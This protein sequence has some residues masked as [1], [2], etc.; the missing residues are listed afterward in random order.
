LNND[1]GSLAILCATQSGGVNVM[2]EFLRLNGADNENNSF[3]PFDLN[4]NALKTSTGDLAIDTTASTG[5][6]NL[7]LTAKPNGNIALS[8]T[9]AGG[10][11]V[12]SA[13]TANGN[14]NLTTTGLGDIVIFSEDTS[15]ITGK[16]GLTLQTVVAGSNLALTSAGS[17]NA[18]STG[19][20]IALSAATSTGAGIITLAPKNA[21]YVNIPSQSD[22]TNDYIRINPQTSANTQQLL[23]TAT[24]TTTSYVNSIN[25]LNLQYRPY[26]ELKADFG[27]ANNKSLQIDINGADSSNNKI[28][29]YD[30]QTNLP[31]QIIANNPSGNGSIELKVNDTSGDLILTG[32]NL[33]AV[34]AGSATNFLRIKINGVYKK[35]QL[36]HD[37]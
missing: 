26:I 4:G 33:E 22:A 23:M 16:S 19:G 30:G 21:A 5:A 34:S 17:I 28:T 36:Y 11:G 10:A 1:D 15:T 12:I 25:L 18:T 32:T 37:V 2:A 29:A 6:G 9:G 24:D 3:R 14:I 8:T 7:T 35:I 20:N 13:T 31:F 27:G